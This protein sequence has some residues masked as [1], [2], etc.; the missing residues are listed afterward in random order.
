MRLIDTATFELH[1]F[2]DPED[3]PGYAILSHS[4]NDVDRHFGLQSDKIKRF[5]AQARED[6]LKYGWV[7]TICLIHKSWGERNQA[8]KE[9]HELAINSMYKWFAH[10]KICYAYLD[11]V[12]INPNLSWEHRRSTVQ[13]ALLSS[14]WFT[15]GWTLIELIAPPRVVFYDANWIEFGT[16]KDM[17]GIISKITG[18]PQEM[19]TGVTKLQDYTIFERMSWARHRMT[20]GLE[21]QAYCLM[22][23]F[24]V[25]MTLDYGES[26]DSEGSN[27]FLRL[28]EAIKQKHGADSLDQPAAPLRLLRIDSLEVESHPIR[29]ESIP[30]YA[31]LSHTWDGKEITY[32]DMQFGR[33]I[34]ERKEFL[35]SNNKLSYDKIMGCCKLAEKNN[36]K[37]VWIDT[38]CIDRTSSSELQE[39]IC[40]MWRWYKNAKTS[41]F[42][43]HY[44]PQTMW[45]Q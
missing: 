43:T 15:S 7:D 1:E 13:K 20:S 4:W 29:G 26:S 5:C 44:I 22:G 36:F 24:E 45:Y 37:Y 2:A 25:E 41:V 10:A 23:L 12:D 21:D 32:Q 17:R 38:C 14:H 30:R 40:S 33:T 11:D 3:C 18:I 8:E 34:E 39:A 9:E 28:R 16:K 6:K 31:I 35:E 19:L 42:P 27:A